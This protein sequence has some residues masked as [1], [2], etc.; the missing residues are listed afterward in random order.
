[1]PSTV[2]AA[3]LGKWFP[4]WTVSRETW[5]EALKPNVSGISTDIILF[6]EHG[7]GRAY[8]PTRELHDQAPAITVQAEA[9]GRWVRHG[10]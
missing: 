4:P 5:R 8:L 2:K 9:A 3:N 1:M 7:G 6:S 10:K